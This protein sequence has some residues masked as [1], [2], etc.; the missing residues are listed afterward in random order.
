MRKKYPFPFRTPRTTP[1]RWLSSKIIRRWL[2]PRPK[3]S[4][5]GDFGHVLIIAGSR[6]MIGAGI[7]SARGALR[8]GA[9]LVTL[10]VPK[11]QQASVIKHLSPEAMTLGLSESSAIP[12]VLGFMKKRRITSLVIGPGL[13]RKTQARTFVRKLLP[14]LGS[15]PTLK[16]I[17]LDADGFIALSGTE[18][19]KKMKIP[20]I[21]T[22]H[23]GELSLFTGTKT[24]ASPAGRKGQAEKFAKLN[25]VICVLKGH[26]TVVASGRATFVNPT[27]NPGMAR[28][29]S[30]DVLSG[31]IGA[32]LPNVR[33]PEAAFKAACA[34]VYVHG[35]A[36][37]LAAREKTEIAMSA[38]DLAEK[39]PSAFKKILR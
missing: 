20:V 30:G 34:G 31:M 18:I 39:I 22:P 26:R 16:G 36:G 1:L 28:G 12:S 29:G 37:D 23:A 38:G 24:S 13:S 7:L 11:D 14:R 27:G 5:K 33:P 17:V 32:L 25:R 21:V 2:R 8:S 35:L 10:A 9:G 6:G 4:H 19:L 15:F 3:N